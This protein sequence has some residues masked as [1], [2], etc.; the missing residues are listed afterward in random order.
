MIR[1]M[2]PED[3]DR[4]LQIEN[5]SFDKPWTRMNFLDEFNNLD[6]SFPKI[7]EVEKNENNGKSDK[8]IIGFIILWLIIDECHLAN[9]AID[10][11]YRHRGYGQRLIDEAISFAKENHCVKVMLEVRKSNIDAIKLYEKNHF[12]NVGIRKEYYHDGFMKTEDAI[13]MD[14]NL[15]S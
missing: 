5:L 8:L 3:V 2:L 6:I 11:D 9:I 15:N 4:V 14:L 10:P 7:L 1:P 13:L 12:I